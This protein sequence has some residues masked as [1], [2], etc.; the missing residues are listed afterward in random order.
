[1]KILSPPINFPF[2]DS[3]IKCLIKSKY[4][5]RKILSAF[6]G[7]Q[8]QIRPTHSS[9]W[10]CD[11]NEWPS[12]PRPLGRLGVLFPLSKI[13]M[14]HICQ[15]IFGKYRSLR[16]TPLST[17]FY[18][19]PPYISGPLITIQSQSWSTNYSHKAHSD[20]WFLILAIDI[21]CLSCT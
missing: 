13:N 3:Q 20:H 11:M 8:Y 16:Y 9:H 5:Y 4:S 10:P 19:L 2:Q 14:N 1:M 17:C 15:Y 21:T 12:S 6:D 18:H 7:L